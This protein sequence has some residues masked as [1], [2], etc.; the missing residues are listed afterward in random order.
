MWACREEELA[1]LL[2]SCSRSITSFT[3]N[4]HSSQACDWRLRCFCAHTHTPVSKHPSV[5]EV[6]S[7]CI[8]CFV[9]CGMK[10]NMML[11]KL[12]KPVLLR[13]LHPN[14]AKIH[15]WFRVPVVG[16]S[17]QA[18]S[19]ASMLLFHWRMET[20]CVCLYVCIISFTICISSVT[21]ARRFIWEMLILTV[22][23]I[24]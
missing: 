6:Y 17:S 4:T 23:S 21:L 2:P 1:A 11:C 7:V 3:T 5:Q 24:Q 12:A 16:N 10:Y 20:R 9:G 14:L 8:T 15:S 13:K 18:V 19:V 22:Y